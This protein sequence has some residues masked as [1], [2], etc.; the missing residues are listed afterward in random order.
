MQSIKTETL[1]QKPPSPHGIMIFTCILG[2]NKNQ[3][4]KD[5]K[6]ENSNK[7]LYLHNFFLPQDSKEHI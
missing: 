2:G 1:E 7:N 5:N 3:R 4:R 6:K